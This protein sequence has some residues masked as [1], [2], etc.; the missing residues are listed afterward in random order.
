MTPKLNPSNTAQPSGTSLAP[1][2]AST[3][4]PAL[5]KLV[6]AAQGYLEKADAPRTSKAYESQWKL[7]CAWCAEHGRDPLPA[8]TDSLILYVTDQAR[9]G[10]TIATIRQALAAI[11]KVHDIAGYESMHKSKGVTR[12]LSGIQRV[13]GS[14][15]KQKKP[16]LNTQLKRVAADIPSTSAGARDRALLLVGFAG[17]FRRSELVSIELQDLTFDEEGVR[18]FLK[19]SKTDQEGKGRHVPIPFGRA[20]ETCPV[21]SL[22]EW[23][24]RAA[25]TTGYVFRSVDRHG[26]IGGGLDGKDVARIVKR[27][28]KHVGLDP[29]AFSG[30]SLRSGLATSAAKAGRSMDSI[31]RTTGHTTVGMVQKYIRS[32]NLFEDNAADGLL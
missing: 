5:E 30:H 27:W 2:P 4:S 10:L 22:Q 32:A 12:T 9:R 25:I 20:I 31:M 18:I 16:L 28:A 23:L 13:H 15:P 29:E 19:R 21:R 7:F 26:N 1:T 11:A 8:A 3:L 17:A 6:E 14:A 24:E